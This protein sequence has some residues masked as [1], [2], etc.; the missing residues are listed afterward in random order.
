MSNQPGM[1]PAGGMGG[2]G[3]A[4]GGSDLGSRAGG[5][6]LSGLNDIDFGYMATP[7]GPEDNDQQQPAA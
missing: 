6:G 7:G 2:F 3:G 4:M 5:T 1:G